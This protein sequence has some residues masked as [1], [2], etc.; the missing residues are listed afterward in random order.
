MDVSLT[1]EQTELVKLVAALGADFG[2]ASPDEVGAA[3][4]KEPGGWAALLECGLVGLGVPA[5]RGGSGAS[6]VELALVC[7]SLARALAPSSFLGGAVAS[8]LLMRA[9]AADLLA[10]Q[11]AGER[12][13]GVV[14]RHDLSALAGPDDPRAVAI[15]GQGGTEALALAPD[16]ELHLM[17]AGGP[18]DNLDLT[19]RTTGVAAAGGQAV[20]RIDADGAARVTALATTLVAADLVG[21]MAGALD[22]AATYANQRQQ[23]GTAIGTFQ[24]IQHMCADALV[25]TESARSA[26]Y[27]A[28]W[29]LG[30]LGA[31]EAL[32]AA[33]VAKAWASPSARMVTETAVQVHGG[34]GI[35]WECR[36]HL[37]LR[38]A[39]LGSALFGSEQQHI[40]AL[41]GKDAP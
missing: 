4:A 25:R 18:Q 31:A 15:E 8:E 26:V 7:E 16:G 36:A 24:A 21:V 19:R 41:A 23:F 1:E 17:A 32:A 2:I 33:R 28:A 39:L 34:I 29:A 38:R 5:S 3:W 22:T 14:L 9:G 40:P 37:Y 12:R 35:T 10:A 30:E 13:F 11:L 27:Y 6:A 20:G